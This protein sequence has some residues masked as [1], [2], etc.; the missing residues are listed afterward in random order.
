M[1]EAP[2]KPLNDNESALLPSRHRTSGIQLEKPRRSAYIIL[3]LAV[4]FL[5]VAL[6]WAN[7]AVLDEV[8]TGQGKVIPSK[9]IQLIQNLEGGIVKEILVQEGDIVEEGQVLVVLDSTRFSANF[10][11]AKQ[12]M[13]ALEFEVARLTAQTQRIPF[14]VNDELKASHPNLAAA[15][16]ALYESWMNG[17]KQLQAAYDLADQELQMTK[18]LV[19]KGAVS[20]VEVLRLERQ[21]N[22][23]QGQIINFQTEALDELSQ[24]RA[25]LL[26]LRETY[27]IHKD[28]LNRAKVRSPV[29]GIV[30]QIEVTTV[31]E[32]S[33]PGTDLMEIVPLDDTLLIEAKIRPSDI[34]F[35][36]PGQNAMVKITAYDFSIYGGLQGTLERISADSIVDEKDEEKT[37]YLI[38][39]RTE[40][41]QLG[42]SEEPLF[43]I[44]GMSATVDIL[45]GEK[46][47]LQ[48]ILKPIL[49]A[50]EKALRER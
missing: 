32:I 26:A 37:F 4:L 50:R 44:P 18:P 34:G 19:A 25:E 10:E 15:E 11:E 13:I 14:V 49:K 40:K 38:H 2:H 33:Q 21:I 20:K 28:R 16:E 46:S 24:D 36:H 35:L 47:V 30:K 29:K 48:Y 22:E 5:V 43:I 31:G 45:T 23:L 9:Q 42:K 6:T 8:T 39:V 41:N 1:K 12:K 27:V 3:W 17:L 7:F